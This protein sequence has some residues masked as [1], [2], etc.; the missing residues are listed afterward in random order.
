[1]INDKYGCFKK[2][3]SKNFPVLETWAANTLK[4]TLSLTGLPQNGTRVEVFERCLGYLL[5]REENPALMSALDE[6]DEDENPVLMSVATKKGES[7]SKPEAIC[8]DVDNEVLKEE[9]AETNWVQCDDCLK[10]RSLPA[11][12]SPDTLP[13]KWSCSMNEWDNDRNACDKD[14]ECN[15]DESASLEAEEEEADEEGDNGLDDEY[16]A[17]VLEIFKK[18]FLEREEKKR[19]SEENKVIMSE[20]RKIARLEKEEQELANYVSKLTPE[21]FVAGKAAATKRN[22]K[23]QI[24]IHRYPELYEDDKATRLLRRDIYFGADVMALDADDRTPLHFAF[25][26]GKPNYRDVLFKHGAEEDCD[27]HSCF[28]FTL[29]YSNGGP[30]KSCLSRSYYTHHR[31][32]W[33]FRSSSSANPGASSRKLPHHTTF[34]FCNALLHS[35]RCASKI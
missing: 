23:Q 6:D 35:G 19:K 25:M 32:S 3:T 33:K 22:W 10:W 2:Y 24:L 5:Y 26:F 1:M 31:C 11:T 12:I 9:K 4:T 34:P 15:L 8:F 27:V 7:E 16:K 20:K 30:R 21:D 13:D 28:H 17:K 14:E 29:P 18:E